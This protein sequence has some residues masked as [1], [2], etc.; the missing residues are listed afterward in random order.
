MV[1][2]QVAGIAGVDAL[3]EVDALRAV[4]HV[5]HH[6]DS[7]SAV[8]ADP[9][10]T[11]RLSR[12]RVPYLLPGIR[13]KGR[14]ID[15]YAEEVAVTLQNLCRLGI[16]AGQSCLYL[17]ERELATVDFARLVRVGRRSVVIGCA[18]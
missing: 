9:L 5:G 7:L 18:E 17:V 4:A 3:G 10:E 6:K 13:M 14:L 16:G 1:S 8:E 2:Q 15:A 12:G 11:N